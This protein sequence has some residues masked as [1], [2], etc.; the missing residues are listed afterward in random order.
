MAKIPSAMITEDHIRKAERRWKRG[1]NTYDDY[2]RNIGKLEAWRPFLTT[3]AS[4]AELKE[5]YKESFWSEVMPE[6]QEGDE[7]W[8]FDSIVGFSGAQGLVMVRDS[9]VIAVYPGV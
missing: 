3:K 7:F 8:N 4:L 1:I 9:K 5:Q 2:Q 6:V